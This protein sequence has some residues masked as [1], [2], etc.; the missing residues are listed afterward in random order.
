MKHNVDSVCFNYVEIK[1][2]LED[3]FLNNEDEC[4]VGKWNGWI[5]VRKKSKQIVRRLLPWSNKRCALH[6]KKGCNA[7]WAKN[8]IRSSQFPKKWVWSIN[9]A[10][11]WFQNDA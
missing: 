5:K 6:N 4:I 10:A 1:M 9:E 8:Y 7:C 11:P 2:S 3:M